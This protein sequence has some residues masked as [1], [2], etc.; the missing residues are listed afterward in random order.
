MGTKMIPIAQ[1]ISVS[2]IVCIPTHVELT[3]TL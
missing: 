1:P 2:I 3:T